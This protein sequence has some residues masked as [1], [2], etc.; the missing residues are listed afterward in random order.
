MPIY[1]K[2][3]TKEYS[4]KNNKLK[5]S[6]LGKLISIDGKTDIYSLVIKNY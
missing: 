1:Y 2:L 4:F 3:I 6:F 5:N